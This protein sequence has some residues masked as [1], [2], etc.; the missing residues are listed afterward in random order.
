MKT[1]FLP[2]GEEGAS[3]GFWILPACFPVF[4]KGLESL[5]KIKIQGSL[6]ALNQFHDF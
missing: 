2:W 6:T 1:D 3:T 4:E 5:K